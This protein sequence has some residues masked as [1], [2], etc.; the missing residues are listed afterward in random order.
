MVR[1][2]ICPACKGNRYIEITAS[3]GK[4]GARKCPHCAGTG[5]KIRLLH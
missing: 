1:K 4:R 3:N 2:E 5:Y